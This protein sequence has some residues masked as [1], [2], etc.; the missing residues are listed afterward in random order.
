MVVVIRINIDD[1]N[2]NHIIW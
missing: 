1:R 2:H